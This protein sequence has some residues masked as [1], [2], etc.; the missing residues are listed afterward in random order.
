MH[1]ND[2]RGEAGRHQAHTHGC[3][4]GPGGLKGG[5]WFGKVFLEK[6]VG[7]CL[8]RECGK[9]GQWAEVSG[10]PIGIAQAPPIH[11][12]NLIIYLHLIRR[13]LLKSYALQR[14]CFDCL[15]PELKKWPKIPN[16]ISW[17]VFFYFVF[18]GII[19]SILPG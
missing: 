10:I 2:H 1:L 8:W 18:K 9:V 12:T 7:W 4:A 6:V 3:G 14:L 15:L 13:I 5:R 19:Q 11:H 16:W 17:K